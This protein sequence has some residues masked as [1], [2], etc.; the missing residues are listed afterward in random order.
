MVMDA[1]EGAESA[2][3][4]FTPGPLNIQYLCVGGW[5]EWGV[6]SGE[7][8]LATCSTVTNRNARGDALLFAAAPEILNA[9]AVSTRFLELEAAGHRERGAANLA[10]HCE[11]QASR[12]WALIAKARGEQ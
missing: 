9:L 11:G 5:D 2:E 4:S 1:K 3:I 6:R 10:E 8:T 7:R 12:N